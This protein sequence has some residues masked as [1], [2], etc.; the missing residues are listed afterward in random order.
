[1]S[2]QTARR[3]LDRTLAGALVLLM[4]ALVIDV[5]W[6]VFTRFV[7]GDPSSYTEELARYL[8]IWLSLLGAAYAAGARLH[9]AVDLL[10]THLVGAAR[11]RLEFVIDA[12]VLLFAVAVLGFGGSRLVW[13][14]LVLG[15]NS[16]ALGI[17]LGWVYLAL[18]LSGLLIAVYTVLH[19][20]EPRGT[21]HGAVRDGGNEHAQDG[22]PAV[23]PRSAT[24]G[25]A[26]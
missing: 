23:D 7:L 18:P 19:L 11:R 21:A 15:Q 12:A 3:I 6:Q 13:V 16:A 2:V 1:M 5:L 24:G 26:H 14:T 10:P 4:A 25:E 22:P 9:L 8:L 17:P 20:V